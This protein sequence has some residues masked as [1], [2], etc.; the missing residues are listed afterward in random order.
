LLN[1]Q[2]IFEP[3]EPINICGIYSLQ[4]LFLKRQHEVSAAYAGLISKRVLTARNML[5][6][7]LSGPLS[8]KLAQIVSTHVGAGVREK[9]TFFFF[10]FE[11]G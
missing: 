7:M 5:I 4:G 3:V 11:V 1:F 8:A 10:K 9:F 6:S 2:L